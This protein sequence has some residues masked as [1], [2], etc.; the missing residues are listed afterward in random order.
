MQPGEHGIIL[1]QNGSGKSVMLLEQ[2]RRAP[3]GPVVVMDTKI[4][5]GFTRLAEKES[6]EIVSSLAEYKRALKRKANKMPDY[7]IVRPPIE[8]V[9]DPEAL[10]LYCQEAYEKT[11]LY[12]LV[13][14][15]YQLH[16]NGRAYPGL[17]GLL[18]RGRSRKISVVLCSQRPKWLSIFCLTEVKHFYIFRLI[19][20]GDR[21]R[22]AELT[23]YNRDTI[24]PEYH[25]YYY[26][27]KSGEYILFAPLDIEQEA[28]QNKLIIKPDLK[29]L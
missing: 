19:D 21:A 5:E 28:D 25:F 11:H 17:I 24:P 23:P 29:W 13:D 7:L 27:I 2:A 4:D 16:N 14:E 18:T 8:E 10:D 3:L 9:T 12:F 15:A 22:I 20:R 1:G 26:N 6:A